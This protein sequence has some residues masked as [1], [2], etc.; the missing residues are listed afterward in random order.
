MVEPYYNAIRLS[1]A[2]YLP[3]PLNTLQRFSLSLS[4]ILCQPHISSLQMSQT[5]PER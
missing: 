2:T 1:S 3:G 5:D 4:K